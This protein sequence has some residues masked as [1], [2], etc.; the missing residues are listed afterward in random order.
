MKTC[1][2]SRVSPRANPSAGLSHTGFSL[3]E[4]LVVI[5]IIAVLISI[6]LPT[7]SKARK[8]SEMI[9]CQAQMKNI[10]DQLVIYMN[11]NDGWL[12][13]PMLGVNVAANERWT[14]KVFKFDKVPN[15][16]TDDPADYT[17]KYM[18]CPSDSTDAILQPDGSSF[19][20][21]GQQNIHTYVISHNTGYREVRYSSR[22]VKGVRI[23]AAE[24][25]IMGEKNSQAPDYYMGTVPILPSY[26]T[27]VCN[28][29]M[30]GRNVGSN[31]LHLDMHVE[32]R[33]ENEALK[34][35]DPWNFGT[36]GPTPNGNP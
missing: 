23:N 7:L 10:G 34:G 26:F 21:P 20:R 2:S 11:N 28:F 31:Y 32:S 24:F 33:R 18:L 29:T 14:T 27:R 30:H 8:Q 12:Y 5:G 4:L 13:P 25:I 1:K 15:P 19:V 6:L 17:P 16:P 3:V 36:L 22:E 9:R 35:I